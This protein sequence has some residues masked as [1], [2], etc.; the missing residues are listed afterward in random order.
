MERARS[1]DGVFLVRSG[2]A[3]TIREVLLRYSAVEER[4]VA[5]G[6]GRKR[7]RGGERYLTKLSVV[8]RRDPLT[9]EQRSLQMAKVRARGN[10]STEMR[11]AGCLIRHGF[12]GWKRHLDLPGRPDFCFVRRRVTVFVDGCFWHG[13]PKCRRNMPNGRRDFWSRKI[14][15]NRRRD[16]K[17]E[18]IL[19]AQCYAVLRI[20][21]HS[22]R[23]DRWLSRLR[24]A[25][26]RAYQRH[27][28]G[29]C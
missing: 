27:R 4:V 11:V 10:R 12:R 8:T 29:L 9:S 5:Y 26:H 24:A 15:S 18:R 25:L 7:L 2:Q 28:N 17:V 19:R 16:R 6:L 20:W 1:G 13:C 14:E 3:T 22:L 21:E 23:D